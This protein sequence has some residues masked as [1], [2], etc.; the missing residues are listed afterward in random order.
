VRSGHVGT[1]LGKRVNIVFS[2]CCWEFENI[3]GRRVSRC[4]LP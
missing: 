1:R 2:N 3:A 4:G